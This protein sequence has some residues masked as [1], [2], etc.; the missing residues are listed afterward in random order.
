MEL[1]SAYLRLLLAFPLVIVFIYICFRFI[2]PRF[3]PAL[4]AGRRMQVVDRVALSTRTFLFVVRVGN[5]YLLLA[6]NSNGVTLL[7]D[8]GECWGEKFNA[9]ATALDKVR[10]GPLT[11][12]TILEGLK[13]KNPKG[14]GRYSGKK[15]FESFLALLGEKAKKARR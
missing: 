7:K 15:I 5:D 9:E 10:E 13:G 14:P 3:A 11:F 2:M 6:S 1:Y 4:G 8:L 12:A